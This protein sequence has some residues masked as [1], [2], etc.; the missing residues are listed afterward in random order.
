MPD[1]LAVDGATL[2]ARARLLRKA[3]HLLH[4]RPL[5]LEG[6]MALVGALEVQHHRNVRLFG[7][8][9]AELMRA[10]AFTEVAAGAVPTGEATE[11]DFIVLDGA[12]S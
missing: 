9:T 11:S 10:Q 8:V 1:T 5:S 7:W 4:D 12:R 6:R 3:M 2:M